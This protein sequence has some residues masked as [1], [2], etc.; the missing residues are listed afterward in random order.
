MLFCFRCEAFAQRFFGLG[1]S[2]EFPPGSLGREPP[3]LRPGSRGREN[4]I[5]ARISKGQSAVPRRSGG[6]GVSVLRRA[7]GSG[8]E[9]LRGLEG[10]AL[11]GAAER[12]VRFAH[13]V[14]CTQPRVVFPP[15]LS[16]A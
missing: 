9:L 10:G 5:H 6:G 13:P 7:T 11:L 2:P 8:P 4:A 15:T 12:F 16:Q 14:I 1:R 3:G